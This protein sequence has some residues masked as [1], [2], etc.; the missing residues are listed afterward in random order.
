MT[1]SISARGTRQ[2]HTSGTRQSHVSALPEGRTQMTLHNMSVSLSLF[3]P[4]HPIMIQIWVYLSSSLRFKPTKM[5]LMG[6]R[7]SPQ[8]AGDALS[9]EDKSFN[10][11]LASGPKWRTSLRSSLLSLVGLY[12]PLGYMNHIRRNQAFMRACFKQS[13][14]VPKLFFRGEGTGDNY[15]NKRRAGCLKYY[16]YYTFIMQSQNLSLPSPRN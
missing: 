4:I 11:N 3:I 7:K 5:D 14:S 12:E 6:V 8:P 10:S 2:S 1:A 13:I 16:E 9:P 15:G